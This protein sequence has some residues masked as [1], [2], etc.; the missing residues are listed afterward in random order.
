MFQHSA[1]RSRPSA[2][3]LAMLTLVLVGCSD[4]KA[5]VDEELARDLQ[6]ATAQPPATPQLSDGPLDAP[7]AAAPTPQR[8]PTR[9]ATT[10]ARPAS[11]RVDT[12]TLR[13]QSPAPAPVME[14]EQQ[15]AVPS[16]FRGLMA[17]T[18][19]GVS[20]RTQV[21]TNSLPGDKIV[22]TVTSPVIGEDGAMIPAGSPVVLEV[23]SVIPGDSPESARLELRVRSVV[24][25]G[26]PRP[27]AGD[28]A[29]TSELEQGPAQAG[30]SD[31]KK[32]IGGAI[33]GAVIGQ[34]MGRDTRS[35]VIGAAAGAAAGT[36]A[37]A[38]TRKHH[39]CLPAGAT[40]RVTTSQPIIL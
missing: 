17:G 3:G 40:V 7:A 25:D 32:V 29:I 4:R 27:V 26:E 24:L 15:A 13:S 9:T 5:Q 39:A 19:I 30:G 14:V 35:T 22:A 16:R 12:T 18:S 36:A 1:F 11:P 34:V 33:A 28:V 6:L 38:A 37:A 20:T 31:K 2:L 10:P 21:C 23:A 8:A